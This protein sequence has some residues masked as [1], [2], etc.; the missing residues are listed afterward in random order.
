MTA[1]YK[2]LLNSRNYQITARDQGDQEKKEEEEEEMMMMRTRTRVP[3][4][5]DLEQ[6]TE[7][8][9]VGGGGVVVE[10][11]LLTSDLYCLDR[12]TLWYCSASVIPR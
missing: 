7:F 8:S 4:C 11:Q 1:F 2:T 5:T 12:N 10:G 6:E 3:S 9:V